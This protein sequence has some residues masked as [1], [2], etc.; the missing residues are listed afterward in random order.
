MITAAH[1]RSLGNLTIVGRAPHE[2]AHGVPL[3]DA[4]HPGGERGALDVDGERERF[5]FGYPSPGLVE[6]ECFRI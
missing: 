5:A 4:V 1:R 2:V 3:L 6:L